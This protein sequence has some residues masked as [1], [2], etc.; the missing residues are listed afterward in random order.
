MENG[1]LCKFCETVNNKDNVYCSSCGK[2]VDGKLI[3]GK[4]KNIIE[5]DYSFC[6]VCGA[7]I[8][9]NNEKVKKKVTVK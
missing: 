5:K 6:P 4:C 8:N 7:H 9:A 2:R 1:V 3:C